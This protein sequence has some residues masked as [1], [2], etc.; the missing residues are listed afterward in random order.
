MPKRILF[1]KEMDSVDIQ[2]LEDADML[3]SEP[4]VCLSHRWIPETLFARLTKERSQ[5]FQQGIPKELLY[6]LLVDALRATFFLGFKYIWIDCLCIYQDD[7]EDWHHQAAVISTIYEQAALNISALSCDEKS[8]ARRLFIQQEPQQAM[9]F[10]TVEDRPV[11]LRQQNHE[12]H[13]FSIDVLFMKELKIH[14]PAYPL[15]TR[16]WVFQERLLS[17]RILHFTERELIWECKEALSCECRYLEALWKQIK[18]QRRNF[19]EWEWT[20]II[21]QYT[22]TNL[23]KASDRLPAIS[24]IAK[25]YGESHGWTYMAGL[26]KEDLLN[27]LVWEVGGT[28]TRRPI[29]QKVPSWSWA[30]VDS[31]VNFLRLTR[32]RYLIEILS[33]DIS[34]GLN[35]FGNPKSA[36]LVVKGPCL[37]AVLRYDDPSRI[38]SVALELQHT[39][40]RFR[41]DYTIMEPGPGYLPTGTELMYLVIRLE[42]LRELGDMIEVFK[43]YGEIARGLVLLCVEPQLGIYERIGFAGTLRSG[44]VNTVSILKENWEYREVILLQIF[45]LSK[46]KRLRLF[47]ELEAS[48]TAKIWEG[49]LD[50]MDT[51]KDCLRGA[52]IIICTLGENRNIPGLHVLQNGARSITA[53]LDILQ[54]EGG[55]KKPRLIFRSAAT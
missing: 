38:V 43:K 16:G 44:D 52:D 27:L 24:G 34:V 28:P 41:V 19:A 31:P 22:A 29:P 54:T 7:L 36:K 23:S 18:S 32:S 50:N 4:Y 10:K 8:S 47:P 12:S 30:S 51:I 3:P 40:L 39:E 9:T 11:F 15:T 46:A 35:P 14:S 5:T 17:R 2:L 37:P 42:D 1:I 55:W 33:P 21:T 25:R 6:P 53:A 48:P 26:W 20:D 49:Q 45:E 13:P